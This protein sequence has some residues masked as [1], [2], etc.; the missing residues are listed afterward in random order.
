MSDVMNPSP[1]L[2]CKL[3]SII[4]HA[5]ELLSPDGHHFDREALAQV[6]ADPEVAEWLRGMGEMALIP[7]K[8]SKPWPSPMSRTS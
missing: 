3:G 1:A 6:L 5:D 8:R 7:L 4:V 2:L